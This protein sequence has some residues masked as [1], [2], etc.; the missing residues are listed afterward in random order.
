MYTDLSNDLIKQVVHLAFPDYKDRKVDVRYN[1]TTTSLVSYWDEG[2]RTYHAIVRLADM[3]KMDISQN[4]SMFDKE[5]L[6]RFTIPDGFVVVDHVIAC[7][8][9]RGIVIKVPTAPLLPTPTAESENLTELDY[10]VLIATASYKSSY[11]GISDLRA[12]ELRRK[13]SYTKEQVAQSRIK[14]QGLGYLD[15]RKA[16]T[17]NGRNIIEN[18]P[19]R[20]HL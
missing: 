20:Y 11:A 12:Y 7:G 16:I 10:R 15:S 13:F 19:D 2:S 5:K 9:D 17:N 6:D 8:K 1:V 3:R 4:G 14:L 18:H